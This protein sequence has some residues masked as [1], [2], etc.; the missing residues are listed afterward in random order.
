MAM[1]RSACSVFVG[2][3]VLGPARWTSIT[4]SGSSVMTARPMAS[5]LSERPGPLVPVTPTAPA[6][7]APM[8]AVQAAISSST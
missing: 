3:P 8:A 7:D 2:I 1:S 6:N 4:T 5:T